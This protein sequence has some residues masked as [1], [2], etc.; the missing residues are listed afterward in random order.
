MA[1]FGSI[2]INYIYTIQITGSSINL[3]AKYISAIRNGSRPETCIEVS[4]KNAETL[5]A[6]PEF[7]GAPQIT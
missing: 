5:S 3:D 1:A 7:V 6:M 4:P 2:R